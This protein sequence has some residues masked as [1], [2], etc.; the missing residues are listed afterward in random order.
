MAEEIE[1]D[2]DQDAELVWHYT[3][4]RGLKSI[5][6]NHVLWASSA[7]FMNDFNE[8]LSGSKLLADLFDSERK[9]LDVDVRNELDRII[10]FSDFSRH[11]KFILSASERG[12][13]LTMWRAYGREE[14][15]YSIGLESSVD[16]APRIQRAG[17]MHPFPPPGYYE[18][19]FEYDEDGYPI[20]VSNDPDFDF[21]EGGAWTPVIYNEG[22]QEKLIRHAFATLRDQVRRSRASDGSDK[23]AES[24]FLPGYFIHEELHQI[25]D[26]GFADEREQR[27]LM[28]V[29]PYWKYVL[30]RAGRFGYVPYLEL[31]I[32]RAGDPGF[33]A[34]DTVQKMERL[35]I[36]K[37]NIG[38]TPYRT[39]AKASLL[40]LLDLLGYHEVAVNVSEIPFR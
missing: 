18:E 36:R 19:E 28:S 23:T 35:P 30:H 34:E 10:G 20:L 39:E 21:I 1:L 8:L 29:N 7:S 9:T 16:L 25:K 38:P 24:F 31:G 37:I 14:V 13:S 17:D 32:P 2:H 6:E 40:Q 11:G 15:S 12:D 26:A 33:L 5:L 22:E 3:D 27:I 4:G